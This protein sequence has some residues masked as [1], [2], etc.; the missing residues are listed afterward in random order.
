MNKQEEELLQCKAKA[1]WEGRKASNLFF[2]FSDPD[3]HPFFFPL[4][5]NHVYLFT[6]YRKTEFVTKVYSRFCILFR[7]SK[8]VSGSHREK[9]TIDPTINVSLSPVLPQAPYLSHITLSTEQ[10]PASARRQTKKNKRAKAEVGPH[11]K[12]NCNLFG[13]CLMTCPALRQL[14]LRHLVLYSGVDE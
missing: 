4:P 8:L 6:L 2:T 11:L 5:L 12:N 9:T 1:G 14:V 13:Q 10:P 3:G 7:A